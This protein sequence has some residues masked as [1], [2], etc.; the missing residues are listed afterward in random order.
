MKS[1]RPHLIARRSRLRRGLRRGLRQWHRRLCVL[2]RSH[3]DGRHRPVQSSLFLAIGAQV[4]RAAA[5]CAGTQVDRATARRALRHRAVPRSDAPPLT[6]HTP[7]CLPP[8]LRQLC[9]YVCGP[10]VAQATVH[11]DGRRAREAGG[12]GPSAATGATKT[13]DDGGVYGGVGVSLPVSLAKP[14]PNHWRCHWHGQLQP[15]HCMMLRQM[16]MD[17]GST[18]RP[19]DF[20]P[21][22]AHGRRPDLGHASNVL[23]SYGNNDAPP[24]EP[25]VQ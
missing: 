19:R 23:R 4:D 10:A 22:A 17:S 5:L 2:R 6:R 15:G 7:P 13:A 18:S 3:A 20:P 9:V 1:A 24:C 14:L 12:R 25:S 8:V 11:E 21:P 16:L